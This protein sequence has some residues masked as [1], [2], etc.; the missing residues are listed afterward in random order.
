[1]NLE[2]LYKQFSGNDSFETPE[3]R[4]SVYLE[5]L[6]KL[7]PGILCSIG[8]CM[9]VKLTGDPYEDEGFYMVD[10]DYFCRRRRSNSFILSGSNGTLGNGTRRKLLCRMCWR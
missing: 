3:D 8:Q 10:S 2:V 9:S 4:K 7:Y 5:S 6:E 1:M